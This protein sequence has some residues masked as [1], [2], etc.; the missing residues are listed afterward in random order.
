MEK[1]SRNKKGVP[2]GVEEH[3]KSRRKKVRGLFEEGSPGEKEL[4]WE[5]KWKTHERE[6]NPVPQFQELRDLIE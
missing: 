4:C 5:I 1:G 6:K 2:G 3:E